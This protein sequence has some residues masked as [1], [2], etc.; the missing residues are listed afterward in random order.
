MASPIGGKTRQDR[1]GGKR[2]VVEKPA[3]N[4]TERMVPE[5]VSQFFHPIIIVDAVMRGPSA[6]EQETKEVPP[7]VQSL[8]A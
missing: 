8:R 7:G 1:Q 2:A 4:G 3:G 6:C 5:Q